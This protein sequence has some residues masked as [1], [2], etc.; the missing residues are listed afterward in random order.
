[1]KSSRYLAIAATAAVSFL[2]AGAVLAQ[3]T[4]TGVGTRPAPG[5]TRP[6]SAPAAAAPAAA[7]A[8]RPA[9]TPPV[10]VIDISEVFKQHSSFNQQLNALKDEIKTLDAYYQAEQKKIVGQRD[11]L[12]SFNAGS[13]EYK[14]LEE[15]I[16]RM[17]SDLQVEMALKQKNVAE[18]EAKVYFNTYNQIYK[19]VEVFADSYGIGLVLRHNNVQMD[20]QKR[21]TVLQGVNRAIVF[22][23]NLDITEEIIK[24]VNAANVAAAPAG[25]GLRQGGTAGGVPAG[26]IPAG[27]V[28]GAGTA[29]NPAAPSF[30][31]R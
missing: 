21:D 23:R 9:S 2:T 27:G 11:K 31:K 10:V 6:V 16:A 17:A 19:Q 15:E 4:G 26:G 7:P 22:Q 3:N 24:R 29:R 8:A 30:P 14:R 13:P 28:T 25:G 18:Q 12:T 20:P 1:M 5:G